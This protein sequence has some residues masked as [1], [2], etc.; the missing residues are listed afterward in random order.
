MT[1]DEGRSPAPTEQ[2]IR[3]ALLG[4]A[5]L[6]RKLE[7]QD[8]LLRNV[9]VLL[10]RLGDL[11]RLIFEYEVRVTERLLPSE[12]PTERESRRIVRDAIER[13]GESVEEWDT[14]WRPPDPESDGRSDG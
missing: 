10:G 11:R 8:L 9:P 13:S 3:R 12:N 14:Q 4:F 1:E 6:I 2:D 5:G 7:E